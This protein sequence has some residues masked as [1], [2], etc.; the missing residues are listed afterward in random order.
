M[1]NFAEHYYVFQ[2]LSVICRYRK[3]NQYKIWLDI[4]F[5]PDKNYKYTTD[6]GDIANQAPVATKCDAH[7]VCFLQSLLQPVYRRKSIS[8]TT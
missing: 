4:E 8:K 6:F 3:L 7:R 1:K 2:H 5:N